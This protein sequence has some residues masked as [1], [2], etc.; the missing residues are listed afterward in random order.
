[1]ILSKHEFPVIEEPRQRENPS[2][3]EF[4]PGN[5]LQHLES[6]LDHTLC[7]F[8]FTNRPKLNRLEI[9]AA[10]NMSVN[11]IPFWLCTFPVTLNAIMIYW[12]FRLQIKCSFI[13]Q[14][15]PYLVDWFTVHTIYNPLMYMFTSIE[16]KR[17]VIN[18]K[19]KIKL[20][21]S[22]V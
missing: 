7:F 17:A 9:R 21:D 4:A 16:F 10:L 11:M 8:W 20:C 6:H 19:N 12:C 15:N 1:M 5:T 2:E 22:R 3:N 18:L 14:T 13:Q